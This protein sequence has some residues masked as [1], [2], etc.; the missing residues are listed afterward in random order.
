MIG[1]CDS[2]MDFYPKE[3]L[4]INERIARFKKVKKYW[5]DKKE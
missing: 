4:K 5:Q 3:I 2:L 1:M